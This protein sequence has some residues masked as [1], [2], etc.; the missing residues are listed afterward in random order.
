MGSAQR[1]LA[2]VQLGGIGVAAVVALTGCAPSIPQSSGPTA[3]DAQPLA[4]RSRGTLKLAWGYQPE[5]LAP[6]FIGGSGNADYQWIF[7]SPLTYVDQSGAAKPLLAQDVPTQSNGAWVVNPDGTMV[8]TYRLRPQNKWHDGRPLTADDFVFAHEVYMDKDLPVTSAVP[9]RFMERV[10]AKDDYTLVIHWKQPYVG[11]N[12]LGFEQLIPL[13][14]HTLEAKYRTN[15]PNFAFGEEWTTAY[16]SAGAFKV[17][18]W[19]PGV[20]LVAAAHMDFSLGP[21]RLDRVEIR[22][23]AD[24]NAQVANLL[25]GEVDMIN[26]PGARAREAVIARDQWGTTDQGY[27]KVWSSQSQYVD[28][29]FR[30]VPNWQRAVTD[31]RV[32]QALLHAVDR[33]ALTEAINLGFAPVAHSFILPEDPLF[34]EVDRVITKYPYDLNRSTALLG[35]AGWRRPSSG[36]QAVSATGQPLDIEMYSSQE[37]ERAATI[38][39]DNW[40][41]AGVNSSIFVIPQARARDGELGSSFPAARVS[42]RGIRPDNFVWI[43]DEFPTAENRWSGSNRGSFFD[44][45][46]DRL[47]KVRMTSLE[48]G[49]RREATIA[50]LKRMTELAGATPFLY[51]VEVVIAR[52]HV[53]GPAG[54]VP[55]QNGMTWNIHEWGLAA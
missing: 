50:V 1:R 34:A 45:E 37:Q 10:E 6:K 54:A 3:A 52:K 17:E 9:E 31:V 19:T 18:R 8:T 38:I 42:S 46:I 24:P 25:S 30:E 22:F 5:N 7:S 41:S 20:G 13:P 27:V 49:Q 48:E 4:A 40:K 36:G 39:I 16:V 11:A 53:A 12:V 2:C 35:E 51:S 55:S 47:Q 43:A 15:K 26:S 23:V 14:R 28:W 21:P 33:D 44:A 29:Q 32:R